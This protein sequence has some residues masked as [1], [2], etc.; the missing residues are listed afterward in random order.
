[1]NL[2]GFG[3]HDDLV[4]SATSLIK[5]MAV[6]STYLDGDEVCLL[7][8]MSADATYGGDDHLAKVMILKSESET[9]RFVEEKDGKR[10]IVGGPE[11]VD[12]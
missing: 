9:V 3:S 2:L 6:M 7:V 12:G 11:T 4:L 1:M 10:V 8:W 5:G